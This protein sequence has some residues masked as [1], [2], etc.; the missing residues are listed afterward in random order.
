[1]SPSDSL[2]DRTARAAHWRFAGLGFGAVSQFGLGVLLARLLAPADFGLMTLAFTVLGLAQPLGDLGIGNAVVQRSELSDRHVRTAFTF[3]LLLGLVITAAIWLLAPVGARLMRDA[4]VTSVLR[5]LAAGFAIG[6]MAVVAGAILRRQLDF[7]QRFFIDGASYV[8]GYGAVAVTLALTGHGVWSLVWGNLVQTML[9]S[10]GVLI[11]V[12]HPLRPLL[13]RRELK[14]LLHF[15]FGSA[16]NACVNYVARNADNLVVGRWVGAA[17]LGLY[18][19]AYNLMNLPHTYAASAMSSVLFPAFA[20]AQHDQLR[21][22]RAFLSVTKLTAM[23]A[24]PAMGTMAIVAPYLVSSLY[25]PRWTGAVLPLQ[26]LCLAG[27]FRALYHLGGVVAQSV[28]RVYSELRN[29]AFYAALVIAGAYVGVR[30]GLPGVAVGVSIAIFCMFIATAHLAL[31]ATGASLG[32]YLRVQI[33][34]LLCTGVTCAA[35][36]SVRMPL[37]LWHAPTLLTT[38]LVLIAAAIPW[39]AGMLWTLGEPDFDSLRS[40]LPR[41]LL[42]LAVAMPRHRWQ[43]R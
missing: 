22:R 42:Q 41:W 7:K 31:Q 35:A 36:F 19:R 37:Q 26:I 34:A 27:Y 9:A 30:Y 32:A 39:A 4:K 43:P 12:R 17:G 16:L 13:A 23:V 40:R 29:E 24:G 1:L 6:G 15:G 3:S 21:V 5:G 18:S 25:G 2:T 14:E 20:Q 11:V 33:G 10:C 28:G 8:L 38:I